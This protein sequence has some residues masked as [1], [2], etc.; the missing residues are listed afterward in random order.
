MSTLAIALI[1][2]GCIFVGMLV[3]M[4][5]RAVLPEHHLSD[6]SKDAVKLGIGMIATLAALVLG[7]LIA[8][9]KSNFDTMKSGLVQTGSKII[10]LDRIMGQY[11]P[12]TR[13]AR[14]LLRRSVATAIDLIWPKDRAF[15]GDGKSMNPREGLESIQEKLLRLSPSNEAQR[16]LLS[17]ALQISGS[18]AEV[19]WMLTEQREQS[20]LPMPFFVMLVF[21]LVIIF[22]TFGMISPPNGTVITVLCVCA[23]SAAGALYMILELDRPY[24]GLIEMSSA[25][26]RSALTYLGQ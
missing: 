12:E 7:L 6:E 4:F 8:S 14:E 17:Q 3:G 22:F 24:G 10:L 26:L 11:G 20:S 19:R 25:P 2:F 18:M 21:W 16:W 5:L 9:A 13:E 1:A 23:L 15:H